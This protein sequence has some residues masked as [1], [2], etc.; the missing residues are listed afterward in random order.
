ML[1]EC[2]CRECNKLLGRIEGR[3]EIMCTRCKVLNHF[4]VSGQ[5]HKELGS[6]WYRDQWEAFRESIPDLVACSECLQLYADGSNHR[7][8]MYDNAIIPN[9]DEKHCE[10]SIR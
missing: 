9:T 7:C 5:L 6:T 10:N 1:Q 8:R 4:Y 3:A 2:R